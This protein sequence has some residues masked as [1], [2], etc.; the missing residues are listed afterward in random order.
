MRACASRPIHRPPRRLTPPCG[1]GGRTDASFEED[2]AS[3]DIGRVTLSFVPPPPFFSSSYSSTVQIPGRC[4]IKHWSGNAEFSSSSLFSSSSSASSSPPPVVACE[5]L[6]GPHP[7]GGLDAEHAPEPRVGEVGEAR[8]G[9]EGVVDLV[10]QRGPVPA[11]VPVARR[12]VQDLLAALVQ[13]D[14]V[15]VVVPVVER[16]DR[17]DHLKKKKKPQVATLLPRRGTAVV[18][19][20]VANSLEPL[21]RGAKKKS[22]STE[23]ELAFDI[24]SKEGIGNGN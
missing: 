22:L 6:P 12:D 9:E 1:E 14:L 17:T 2:G 5:L 18:A 11:H 15:G 20:G 10:R 19:G 21:I 7:P 16:L 24:R 13:T 8:V 4:L 23:C 3:P